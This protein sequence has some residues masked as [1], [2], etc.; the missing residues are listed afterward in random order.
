MFMQKFE[1]YP[2]FVKLLNI[3]RTKNHQIHFVLE[4]YPD[5][6]SDKIMA[7]REPFKLKDI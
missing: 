1:D 2:Y 3:E 5:V 7:Q 4:Y 6:L